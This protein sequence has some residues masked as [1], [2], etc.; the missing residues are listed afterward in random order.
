LASPSSPW[1]ADMDC[2]ENSSHLSLGEAH[3]FH[4]RSLDMGISIGNC[5]G[6]NGNGD[7]NGVIINSLQGPGGTNLSIS[8]KEDVVSHVCS[9][10][11]RSPIACSGRNRSNS[12]K[13]RNA[14]KV[15]SVV[16]PAAASWRG[17]YLLTMMEPLLPP[18][19][20]SAP[21]FRPKD[22]VGRCS[23]GDYLSPGTIQMLPAIH[24]AKESL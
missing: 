16:L 5:C 2:K 15:N 14:P 23:F 21:G 20:Q 19:A 24:H 6:S 10:S 18:L 22:V 17:W 12:W 3:L 1:L 7:A 13:A 11:S 4:P 8:N 9:R